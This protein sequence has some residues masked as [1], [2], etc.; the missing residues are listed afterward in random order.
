MEY[1]TVADTSIGSELQSRRSFSVDSLVEMIISGQGQLAADT[2][3]FF[4]KPSGFHSQLTAVRESLVGLFPPATSANQRAS[5]SFLCDMTLDLS[6]LLV[7]WNLLGSGSNTESTLTEADIQTECTK[8]VAT[9]LKWEKMAPRASLQLLSGL[10]NDETARLTAERAQDPGAQAKATVGSSICDYMANATS[11][12]SSSNLRRI[13][14]MHFSGLTRTELGN[15]YAAFLR[16]AMYLGASFVTTNPVMVGMAWEADPAH[17]DPIMGSLV[18]ANPE[19]DEDQ[20]ARL[21]T[22]EV[23]IVNMRF[24][25]PIF[26]LTNGTMGY[27]SLQVNPK[28]HGDAQAMIADASDI[29]RRLQSRLNGL[30]PNVIF[31]LP[32]T[33]AGLEACRSL[34]SRGIGVN[35]TVNAG[36]FQ[37][38][39]FA[40]AIKQGYAPY[41]ALTEINGRLAYP[42]RDELLRRLPELA[43]KGTDEADV[44]E[45]AAW[46]GVA[47]VKKLH[48]LLESKSYDLNRIRPLVAST[49]VY[50]DHPGYERLPSRYPDITETI[51]TGI[52]T[53]FPD[54]RRAFD[55]EGN[56]P[57]SPHRV[58]EPVPGHVLET[59][60]NSQMFRQAYYV[61]GQEWVVGE[62][63]RF[64]PDHELALEEEAAVAAWPPVRDTLA[65][66]VNGYDRFVQRLMA[67]R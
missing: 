8:N 49:R 23:V 27:V 67:L 14:E 52:I 34:T 6:S 42:V 11:T 38:L 57:L 36:L 3:V 44:R 58:A 33:L 60:A 66:F 19:A 2:L 22:L 15:D 24:L 1:L 28:K 32:A 56:L 18:A 59:L 50:K 9:L 46:A 51:G 40:E 53:V 62:D 45:A 17:W 26:L 55:D 20:L 5:M 39:R 54:V 12:I 16:H 65:Q 29:Y 43:T 21:A 48:A 35:I 13:A 61:T 10:K 41:S 37:Q 63:Q 30:I 64:R 47:V 7:R 4:S 31:K 25:R